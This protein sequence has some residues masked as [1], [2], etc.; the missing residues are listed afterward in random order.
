GGWGGGG[1][2]GRVKSWPVDRPRNWLA[3]VNRPMAEKAL[4][5]VRQSAAR[6]VPLGADRWKRRIADRLGLQVALRPRGRPRKV[7]PEAGAAE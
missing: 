3:D 4:K 5:V 1:L 2:G 7:S 6:G